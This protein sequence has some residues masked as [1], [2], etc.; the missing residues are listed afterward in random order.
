MEPPLPE[1][2][3]DE[4]DEDYDYYTHGHNCAD[5][6]AGYVPRGM[7]ATGK[8]AA[9]SK[10]GG[11][12]ELLRRWLIKYCIDLCLPKKYRPKCQM[13]ESEQPRYVHIMGRVDPASLALVAAHFNGATEIRVGCCCA[14]WMTGYFGEGITHHNVDPVDFGIRY[15]IWH[16]DC[17]H[18]EFETENAAKA[19]EAGKQ[20]VK[21]LVWS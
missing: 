11:R 21:R 9:F 3:S 4:D 14:A 8:W 20:S 12:K 7:R 13:C 18:K 1:L 5:A 16:N 19:K 2:E 6:L 17:A 15:K 10:P